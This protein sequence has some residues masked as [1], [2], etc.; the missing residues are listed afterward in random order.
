MTSPIQ[1]CPHCGA[2]PRSLGKFCEFCGSLLLVPPVVAESALV[3]SLERRFERLESHPSFA[4]LLSKRPSAA[5]KIASSMIGVVFAAV[6]IVVSGMMVF[7]FSFTGP[8]VLVP[9]LILGVGIYVFLRALGQGTRL[10]TAELVARPAVIAGERT[11]IDGG[12]DGPGHTQYFVTIEARDGKRTE[13]AASGLLVGRVAEGDIG[14]AYVKADHLL[15]F[16]RV[17]V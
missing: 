10:A 5:G 11:R 7:A 3:E 15:D 14:V 6:F 17:R 2:R 12:G 4:S 16:E 8:L 13:L 9:L 1:N